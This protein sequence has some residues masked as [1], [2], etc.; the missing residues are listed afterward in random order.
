M[1]LAVPSSL[2]VNTLCK[3]GKTGGIRTGKSL[4]RSPSSKPRFSLAAGN[5][6]TNLF[7]ALQIGGAAPA[8]DISPWG[9][10]SPTSPSP[11]GPGSSG[12]RRGE[13][14]RQLPEE[15]DAGRGGKIK[16]EPNKEPRSELLLVF[17]WVLAAERYVP[18]QGP[19]TPPLPGSSRRWPGPHR[20][21]RRQGT[22]SP[23][24]PGRTPP[25]RPLPTPRMQQCGAAPPETPSAISS[26][27]STQGETSF[28]AH[29]LPRTRCRAGTRPGA[30]HPG[31]QNPGSALVDA[32]SLFPVPCSSARLLQLLVP[33]PRDGPARF[34]CGTD[35][36]GQQHAGTCHRVPRSQSSPVRAGHGLGG[37]RVTP[38]V[39]V[40]PSHH[41]GAAVKD[42]QPTRHRKSRGLSPSVTWTQRIPAVSVP[43]QCDKTVCK[44]T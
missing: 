16:K 31:C 42:T 17:L 38:R 21:P 25:G 37:C 19:L 1:L 14:A 11:R 40:T 39:P 35:L 23:R 34:G 2:S 13:G 3:A 33:G 10:G 9:C 27:R 7:P 29:T 8:V 20:R 18:A 36:P 26:P 44:C 5:S 15:A 12:G 24:C 30:R 32:R 41:Q 6:Q 4:S 43:A 22:R 28:T